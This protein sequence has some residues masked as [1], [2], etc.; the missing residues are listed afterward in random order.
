M[1]DFDQILNKV[2]AEYGLGGDICAEHAQFQPCQHAA[3]LPALPKEYGKAAEIL[4][5]NPD[6]LKEF[7]PF[8]NL[9]DK[10]VRDALTRA[11]AANG[12]R[13]AGG[14][15]VKLINASAVKEKRTRWLWEGRIPLG[16]LTFIIGKGGVGK[17]TELARQVALITMGKMEGEYLGTPQSVIYVASED[18]IE[19]TVKPR[20]V[21]AGADLDRVEFLIMVQGEDETETRLI[22]EDDL[23]DVADAVRETGA[24]AVFFDP[25]SSNLGGDKNKQNEMRPIMEKIRRGAQDLGVAFVALG[26]VKKERVTSV[27]DAFLGSVEMSNVCRSAMGAVADPDE[28]GTCIL[29]QEKMNLGVKPPSLRYKIEGVEYPYDENGSTRTMKTSR[30]VILGETDRTASDIM[31][32]A[33]TTDGGIAAREAAEWLHDYLERSGKVPKKDVLAKSAADGLSRASIDRAAK[34]LKVESTREGFGGGSYWSLPAP[35]GRSSLGT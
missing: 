16:E 23:T 33:M 19:A 8:L 25:L 31:Q 32:E 27:L 9:L 13:D 34:K 29:S 26:H 28:E 22:L 7:E 14:R 2:T 6:L 30:T 10:P 18:S 11:V 5:L 15:R 21:A 4:R 35:S 17:S 1:E 20:M 12:E 3:H 24:V